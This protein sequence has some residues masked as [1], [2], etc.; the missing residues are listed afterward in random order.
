[1]LDEFIPLV[2]GSHHD[3]VRYYLKDGQLAVA[4]KNGNETSLK[5]SEWLAGYNGSPENPTSL[6]F[7][8]NQLHFDLLFD[9]ND[10]VCAGDPAGIR[11][12]IMEAATTTILDCED[13]VAAVDADDKVLVYP[14]SAWCLEWRSGRKRDQERNDFRAP[15]EQGS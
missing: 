14:E 2:A 7:K 6:L 11:D 15:D 9:K 12:I 10:P 5:Q 1:M 13:A 8:Q 4:L 3:A